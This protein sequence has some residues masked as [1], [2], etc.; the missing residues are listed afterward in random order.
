MTFYVASGVANTERVSRAAAVLSALGHARTYDWTTHGSVAA[1][2]SKRK[3]EVA[4]A[5]VSA[6]SEADLVLILLPGGR[7]THTELHAGHEYFEIIH[8]GAILRVDGQ[9]Q[10]KSRLAVI[11]S[12][13]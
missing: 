13:I 8:N 6:I 7:G 9:I 11:D 4:A 1:E 10:R 12:D 3:S 5:E 2:P